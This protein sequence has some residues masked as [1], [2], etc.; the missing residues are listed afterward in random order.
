MHISKQY[1]NPECIAVLE[2]AALDPRNRTLL[3]G[4]TIQH[5]AIGSLIRMNLEASAQAASRLIKLFSK[6]EADEFQLY[7][8]V[9]GLQFP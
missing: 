7:L 9:E 3:L 2:S 4:R 8:R 1:P 6:D 5:T